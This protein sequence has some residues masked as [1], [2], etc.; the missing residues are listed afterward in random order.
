MESNRIEST[1][2]MMKIVT[3]LLL[4]YHRRRHQLVNSVSSNDNDTRLASTN[5]F[6]HYWTWHQ[7]AP[8]LSHLIIL[9]LPFFLQLL[10]VHI[11]IQ[12]NILILIWICP[13]H[14]TQWWMM[15]P[16]FPTIPL[17]M[18]LPMSHIYPTVSVLRPCPISTQPVLA[19][20]STRTAIDENRN[21][22]TSNLN[23]ISLHVPTYQW[24]ITR[25]RPSFKRFDSVRWY[26]LRQNEPYKERGGRQY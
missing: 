25:N 11:S 24:E 6:N 3:M 2:P 23:S 13:L 9:G 12:C 26:T 20:T 15:P 21:S 18:P 17:T 1:G 10:E 4:R 7:T 16:I 8:D 19:N 14:Q 22:I 5:N